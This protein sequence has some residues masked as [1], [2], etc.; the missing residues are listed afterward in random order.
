ML[1]SITFLVYVRYLHLFQ[2]FK[3]WKVSQGRRLLLLISWCCSLTHR[4]VSLA[5]SPPLRH[6]EGKYAGLLL[7]SYDRTL[8]I[9]EIS[10]E[11]VAEM[12][13][14]LS[15][16]HQVGLTQVYMS[17]KGQRVGSI[18]KLET[19]AFRPLFCG[20]NSQFGYWRE[21]LSLLLQ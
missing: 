8:V 11:E 21:A 13:N 10:S 1:R 5:R 6:D 18:L 7:T 14:A 12:H 2:H 20:T 15:A 19:P 17:F 3:M 9:K 16:Y 4:Q